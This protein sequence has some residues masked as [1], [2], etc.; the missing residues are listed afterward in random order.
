MSAWRRLGRSAPLAALTVAGACLAGL[1]AT[2]ASW[3]DAS[4]AVGPLDGVVALDMPEAVLGCDVD[5]ADVVV[6][7][8]MVTEPTALDYIVTL[9]GAVETAT[10]SGGLAVLRISGSLLGGLSGGSVEVSVV[11]A[12][13]GSSWVSDPSV[14]TVESIP[15]AGPICP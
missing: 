3:T 8:P 6:S 15:L 11:A 4:S 2:A 5:G 14:L 12:L 7:W 10:E 9:D 1:P 13:P